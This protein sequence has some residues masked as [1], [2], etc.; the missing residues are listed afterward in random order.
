M[1]E[2]SLVQRKVSVLAGESPYHVVGIPAPPQHLG[3]YAAMATEGCRCG[4][5]F[6][7]T[8]V[9]CL[10]TKE[11]ASA[12]GGEAILQSDKIVYSDTL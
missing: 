2:D 12:E 5:L 1:L 7:C 8:E 9:F 6:G 10:T 3:R 11:Y 4:W